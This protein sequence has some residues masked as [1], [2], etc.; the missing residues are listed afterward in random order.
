MF[1]YGKV[2]W[3]ICLNVTIVIYE[4]LDCDET[5]VCVSIQSI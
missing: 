2:W 5:L 1:M 3:V 4:Q